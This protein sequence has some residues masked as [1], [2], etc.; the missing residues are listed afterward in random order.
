MGLIEEYQPKSLDVIVFRGQWWNPFLVPVLFRTQSLWTHTV[1]VRGS[2][3]RIYD[4]HIKGVEERSL[5]DYKNRYAAVLRRIDI[6]EIPLPVKIKI[7]AWLDKLVKDKNDY[8]FLALVGFLSG[9]KAFEDDDKWFCSEVPYWMWQYFWKPMFNEELT[10][11][12]PSDHYRNCC[13]K[14]VCEGVM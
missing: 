2:T 9:I 12:W 8:D 7:I 6:D 13:Y 11:V 10:Y 1:V 5:S 14:I 4:A 3:G